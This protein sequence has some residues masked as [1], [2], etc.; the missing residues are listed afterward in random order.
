MVWRESTIATLIHARMLIDLIQECHL[1]R[2][3]SM[4][5]LKVYV[6]VLWNKEIAARV[7]IHW[8]R[9]LRETLNL[10]ILLLDTIRGWRGAMIENLLLRYLVPLDDV[11]G[12]CHALLNTC[13][14]Y[15]A[16]ILN[17]QLL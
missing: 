10:D 17:A 7:V 16:T 12:R 14:F 5:L 4:L 1:R 8:L 13:S 15:I 3:G 6:G 9:Y 2:A 11:R